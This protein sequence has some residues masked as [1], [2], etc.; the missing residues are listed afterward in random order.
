MIFC[1]ITVVFYQ[2]T[3][4]WTSPLVFVCDLSQ[5][6]GEELHGESFL[7]S[8]TETA[9]KQ[10]QKQTKKI[11]ACICL[12]CQAWMCGKPVCLCAQPYLYSH[13]SLLVLFSCWWDVAWRWLLCNLPLRAA[14]AV[15]IPGMPT[16]HLVSLEN[17]KWVSA[18][19]WE[20]S[21]HLWHWKHA[22]MQVLCSTRALWYKFT[23]WE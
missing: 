13:W 17:K 7:V 1:F 14:N 5:C 6:L 11:S 10:G 15:Q 12:D 18:K 4:S 19:Y 2:K 21:D 20:S 9:T 16:S 8:Q 3:W 23:F 22:V